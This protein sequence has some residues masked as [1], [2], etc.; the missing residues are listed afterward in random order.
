MDGVGPFQAGEGIV[1]GIRSGDWVDVSLS[2]LSAGASLVDAVLNPIATLVSI[3]ASWLLEHLSP[4]KDWLDDLTGDWRMVQSY[5]VTWQNVSGRIGT[6]AETLER[7]LAQLERMSGAT[8]DAYELLVRTM[9]KTLEGAATAA[10]AVSEAVALLSTIVK[11]VHDMVRAVLSQRVGFI[12]PELAEIAATLG[13]ASPLVAAQVAAK[14]ADWSKLLLDFIKGLVKSVGNYIT[15]AG[16]L[17]SL[18]DAVET[19]LKSHA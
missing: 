11:A 18:Y 5:S 2:G 16:Q 19:A 12:V 7:S 14:T 4:L 13:I 9:A 8:V 3:G 15:V 1:N 6:T 17:K 10:S